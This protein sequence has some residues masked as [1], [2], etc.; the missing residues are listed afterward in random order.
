MKKHV[1]LVPLCMF[2]CVCSKT[3]TAERRIPVA[4]PADKLN[5]KNSF[6]FAKSG[7]VE[8]VKAVQSLKS[9][10][11]I[12]VNHINQVVDG[13]PISPRSSPTGSP[14]VMK[15]IRLTKSQ[16]Q[17]AKAKEDK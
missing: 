11:S 6:P 3:N 9:T 5:K 4:S 17:I 10:S 1:F 13:S 2:F 15:S 16:E 8:P 14:Q 12:D 7:Y